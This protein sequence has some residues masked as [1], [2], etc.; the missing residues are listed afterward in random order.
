MKK[1]MLVFAV[2]ALVGGFAFAGGTKDTEPETQTVPYG[3]GMQWEEADPVSLT[4]TLVLEDDRFAKLE[5][6]GKTYY[7]MYPYWLADDIDVTDGEEITVEGYIG[8]GP[9]FSSDEP[10]VMVTKAVI[11]GKEYDLTDEHYGLMGGRGGMRGGR[12]GPSGRFDDRSRDWRP[13]P[14]QRT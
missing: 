3:R 11:D 4:G 9:R 14:G 12:R 7:L 1:I 2:L 13:A 8:H 10:A 5:S 6:G